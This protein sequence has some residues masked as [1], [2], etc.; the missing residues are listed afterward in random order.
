M[1]PLDGDSV[2]L[3][4]LAAIDLSY[5]GFCPFDVSVGIYP[6]VTF[7][8]EDCCMDGR[9]HLSVSE[10]NEKFVALRESELSPLPSIH[11]DT[12]QAKTSPPPGGNVRDETHFVPPSVT[13]LSDG[14]AFE[15]V[16]RECWIR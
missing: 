3:S 1:L 15:K 10:A 12:H 7:R 14:F 2:S 16:P 6:I 4:P 5:L 11:S 13:Q 8:E 9:D